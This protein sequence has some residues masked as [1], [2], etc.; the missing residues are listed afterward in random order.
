MNSSINMEKSS[1]EDGIKTKYPSQ[2]RFNRKNDTNG[3][4]NYKFAAQK[5]ELLLTGNFFDEAER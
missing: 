5:S 2:Y 4:V 1:S 3:V